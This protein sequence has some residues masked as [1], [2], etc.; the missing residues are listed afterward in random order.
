M[1]YQNKI[2]ALQALFGTTVI[3]VQEDA[4]RVAGKRYPIIDDVIILTEPNQYTARVRHALQTRSQEASVSSVQGNGHHGSFAEDIQ[5]TFGEEWQSYGSILPEHWKEFTEY[6][7]LVDLQALASARVCDL[8]CGMGRWSYFIKDYCREIVLVDFSDAIFMARRNLEQ[9]PNALFFMCDL[10]HLP[11]QDNFVDFL[12]CLGVLHH[13]PTPCLD[14]VRRLKRFAP[15]LLIFLYY[16]L[17]NRPWYFRSL[18]KVV[19]GVRGIVSRVRNTTFRKIFSWAG[20]WCLYLPLITLGRLLKPFGG[21][22]RVP[23]YEYY[24]DKS[25]RRIE[26]D[27]YDRFFTRIEQRVTRE[28]V[29]GLKDTYKQ[30]TLSDH[31]PYWHFIC[32]R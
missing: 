22:D 6:F 24:H 8:G 17:D 9:A 30:I 14:E 27:V 7:D 20:T 15:F 23:L 25:V 12:F 16:A 11:F 10:Q 26:Q 29:L 21:S 32:E 18:L 13:L 3:E 2:P 28:E 1:Y 31:F 5:F 19:T 4:L